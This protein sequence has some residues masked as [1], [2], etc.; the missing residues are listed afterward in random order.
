MRS[1]GIRTLERALPKLDPLEHPMSR[2]RSDIGWRARYRRPSPSRSPTTIQATPPRKPCSRVNTRT[3]IH[4]PPYGRLRWPPATS[5][6]C[7][8]EATANRAT[9]DRARLRAPTLHARHGWTI[10]PLAQPDHPGP[11]A[12]FP[13]RSAKS[14]AFGDT[15]GAFHRSAAGTH[16]GLLALS[17]LPAGC[18]P[19][20]LTSLWRAHGAFFDSRCGRRL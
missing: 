14:D 2:S 13:R 8:R 16:P 11:R 4:G 15:R 17:C 12:R 20:L 19:Q 6:R 9:S 3:R 1:A 7:S 18:Y 5:T 10:E